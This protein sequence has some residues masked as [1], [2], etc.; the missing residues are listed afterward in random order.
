MSEKPIHLEDFFDLPKSS[1]RKVSQYFQLE[2]K[3]IFKMVISLLESPNIEDSK[4]IDILLHLVQFK[5]TEP[6]RLIFITNWQAYSTQYKFSLSLRSVFSK[7]DEKQAPID[8]IDSE[9]DLILQDTIEK[10]KEFK[11]QSANYAKSIKTKNK[12]HQYMISTNLSRVQLERLF[13]ELV[14]HNFIGAQTTRSVPKE[15]N[16]QLNKFIQLFYKPN[17]I[18]DFENEKIR[19]L[20]A[21]KNKQPNKKALYLLFK[22]MHEF[23][24]DNTLPLIEY[25]DGE[26]LFKILISNFVDFNGKKFS[27]FTHSNKKTQPEIEPACISTYYKIFQKVIAY[28]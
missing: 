19:W 22:T 6:E 16:G 7:E 24:I 5:V 14:Q 18:L 2:S 28:N 10:I 17:F 8:I 25:I 23:R 4:I 3:S 1:S 15:A 27:K 26:D 9:L 20:P 21:G 11:F 13:N 12:T